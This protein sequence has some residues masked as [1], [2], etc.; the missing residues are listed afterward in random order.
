MAE[1]GMQCPATGVKA[2]STPFSAS[3]P[4]ME[5]ALEKAKKE[6]FAFK[7]GVNAKLEKQAGKLVGKGEL[8]KANDLLGRRT[9]KVAMNIKTYVRGYINQ[10]AES[11]EMWVAELDNLLMNGKSEHKIFCLRQ[12]GRFETLDLPASK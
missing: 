4:A 6:Y 3:V 1:N 7:C 12:F 5:I 9:D 8:A 11:R 10:H 2:S